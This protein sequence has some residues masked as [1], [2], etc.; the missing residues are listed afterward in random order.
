MTQS[1]GGG[2]AERSTAQLSQ[3]LDGLGH[4]VHIISILSPV[5]FPYGGRLHN[6][7]IMKDANDGFVARIRRFLFF[8]RLIKRENFDLIIDNRPRGNALRELMYYVF[9]YQISKTIFV[10][11]SAA[12]EIYFPS[13]HWVIF[14]FYKRAKKVVCVSREIADQVKLKYTLNNVIC[15]YNPVFEMFSP[16]FF[17]LEGPYIL[18]YGRFDEAVKNHS[19]LLEAYQLS[20][21]RDKEIKLVL[22]GQ[23]N[24]E[25]LLKQ[26]VALLGIKN[27]VVFKKFVPN[28][29]SII[30]SAY[31]VTLTSRYEGFPRVLIESLSLGVPVVS[32]DCTSGP[33]EIVVN[34]KNGLLVEN[35]NP[36]KLAAAF[37]RMLT[38]GALYSEMKKNAKSSIAHLKPERIAQQWQKLIT[39]S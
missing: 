9:L 5:D 30:K 36:Q 29:A 27:Q 25:D 10:V 32:V 37:D 33:K 4:E 34:E 17:D 3:L 35:H 15:I 31:F 38:D 18:A 19:L 11:R 16:D 20:K 2:G 21:L 13:W 28:P 22:L 6:L 12:L 14:L 26:K 8:R 7:G 24:E 39:S 1:L 23:G